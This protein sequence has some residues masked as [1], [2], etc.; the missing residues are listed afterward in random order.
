MMLILIMASM[1]IC[2]VIINFV[3]LEPYYVM[4]EKKQI[5]EAYHSLDKIFEQDTVKNTSIEEVARTYN[6]RILIT[7]PVGQL[8]YSSESQQGMIYRDMKSI[9]ENIDTLQSQ[10]STNGYAV[11]T[12]SNKSGTGTSLNLMGI[13][14]ASIRSL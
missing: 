13:W 11:V 6:Y 12:N 14:T 3:M 2:S 8:V 5:K 10:M 9:L 4:K 7:D 1:I